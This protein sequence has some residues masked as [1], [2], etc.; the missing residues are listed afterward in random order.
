MKREMC[1]QYVVCKQNL[2]WNMNMSYFILR[3]CQHIRLLCTES[4]FHLHQTVI[5]WNVTMHFIGEYSAPE[6]SNLHWQVIK[7]S[8]CREVQW[9]Q[10]TIIEMSCSSVTISLLWYL[11]QLHF[12][13]LIMVHFRQRKNYIFIMNLFLIT[14]TCLRSWLLFQAGI[15]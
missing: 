10:C 15:W 9:F 14:E 6:H 11:R 5:L 3:M 12:K 13:Q 4:I 1:L 7:C 2:H 8:Q